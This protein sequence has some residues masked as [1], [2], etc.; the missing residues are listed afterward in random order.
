MTRPAPSIKGI[1]LSNLINDV[2]ELRNSGRVAPEAIDARLEKADL[3]LLETKPGPADWIPIDRYRRLSELLWDIEGGRSPDYLERRGRASAELVLATGLY[4]QLDFL[5][6]RY[7]ASDLSSSRASLKLVVTLQGSLI[8]FGDWQIEQDPDHENRLQIRITDA[9][10]FPEA[11]CHAMVGFLNRLA[12]TREAKG[13][14]FF[15]RPTQD[16]VQF[17]MTA[18]I[19]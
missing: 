5:Q 19:V 4:P 2:I 13:Q 11:L 9:T 8:N 10:D 18:S 1:V 16:V 15:E 6:N 14:W 3:E 17:R 7:D 12:E